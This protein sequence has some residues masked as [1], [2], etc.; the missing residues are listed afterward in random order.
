ML[1]R[2]TTNI[3]AA[4]VAHNKIPQQEL[5]SLVAMVYGALQQLEHPT[6]VL[7]QEPEP[8]LPTPA[9]IRKSIT[10]DHLISFETGKPYKSLKRH[11]RTIGLSPDG[12]REKWGLPAN[13]PMVA[14]SYSQRRSELAKNNK[15]GHSRK[16]R[17]RRAA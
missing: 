15:F 5:T 4:Y 10:R 11:L 6:A 9:Q 2:L 16:I 13:Y 3:V 14:E 1:E 12:Y 17:K 8:V 7:M